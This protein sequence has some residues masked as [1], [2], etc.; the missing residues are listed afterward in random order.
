MTDKQPQHGPGTVLNSWRHHKFLL[1]VGATIIVS[2]ILV[3]VA[4]GMYAS[5]GAAQLDL[6][7]PNYQAVREQANRDE[8]LTGF[9]ATGKITKESLSEFR[10]SYEPQSKRII[11]FESFGGD[12]LSDQAL[13]IDAPAAEPAP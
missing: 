10:S 3:G 13:G 5:S 8:R 11:D 4:M 7:R 9:P 1:L 12:P 2:L 6:S